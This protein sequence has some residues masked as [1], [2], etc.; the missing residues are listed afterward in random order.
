MNR[1]DGGRS[2][3]I[4][5]LM[6]VAMMSGGLGM[7]HAGRASFHVGP[8]PRTYTVEEGQGIARQIAEQRHAKRK[9]RNR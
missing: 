2:H 3:V 1:K 9:R 7:G 6:A 8:A 5:T 4:G